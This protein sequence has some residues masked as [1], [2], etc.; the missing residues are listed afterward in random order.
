MPRIARVRAQA[1]IGIGVY[2]DDGCDAETL[3]KNAR[4]AMLNAKFGSD[5]GRCARPVVNSGLGVML[6]TNDRSIVTGQSSHRR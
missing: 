2:P 1:T 3:I 6:C 5:D 4:I